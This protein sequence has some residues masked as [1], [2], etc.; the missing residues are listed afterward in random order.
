M[1]D[2]QGLALIKEA[3]ESAKARYQAHPG[4]AEAAWQFAR[5]CFDRADNAGKDAEK[6]FAAKEGIAACEQA[7]RAQPNSAAAYYYLGMNQGQLAQTKVF[8]ALTL[9]KEMDKAWKKARELDESVDFAGPDRNLALLYRDAPR[10]PLSIGN[11][12][13]AEECA[14][15][16]IALAPSYPENRLNLV[17][18]YLKWSRWAAAAEADDKLK[19]ILPDARRQLSG[20]RWHNDW[21]DWDRRQAAVEKK[22]RAWRDSAERGK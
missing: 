21:E 12:A 15:R 7:L 13:K 14:L 4:D 22:I 1:A 18:T 20:P 10:P 19:D 8:G 6:A 5:A 3:Y 11:R 17:E 16:A 9:V 2:P